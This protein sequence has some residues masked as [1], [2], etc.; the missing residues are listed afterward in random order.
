[1]IYLDNL[2]STP[3]APTVIE[4]MQEVLRESYAN[5]HATH[6][7]GR[8]AYHIVEAAKQSVARL[9][10]SEPGEIIF[11]S[12]ASEANNQAI[13]GI[14]FAGRRQGRHIVMSA[15]EHSCCLAAA[16]WLETQGFELTLVQPDPHGVVRAE[17]VLA[18]IRANTVLVSVQLANN[19]VGTIQPIA[20]IA[21]ACRRIGVTV[22][23]DAAQA[24]GKIPV[25]VTDLGVD[26]LSL[27]GHKFYGPKGIGALWIAADCPIRPDAIIH[28][29]GQQ[30]GC[31]AG[32]IPTFL[33]HGLGVAASI[34][35]EHIETYRSHVAEM[36]SDFRSVLQQDNLPF[37]E[38]GASAARIPG[39]L[40]LRFPGAE[41]FDVLDRLDGVVAVSTGSACS[42]GK[43]QPSHVLVAMGLDSR[44][45]AE[46]IRIGLGRTTTAEE[47]RAAAKAVANAVTAAQRFHV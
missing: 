22:H 10:G 5:P 39:C 38:H 9:I 35:Q 11:T 7:A 31:R 33:C 12:G 46:T 36:E 45:I 44:A 3:V 4:A 27:S 17:D 26:L 34:A 15:I 24:V 8:H 14:A 23:T 18:V 43:T 47:A 40:S 13:K 19:E 25:D 20:E 29:G 16:R 42:A 1:M 30:S 6:L 28:G 2:A 32:T 37:V 41:A 21:D